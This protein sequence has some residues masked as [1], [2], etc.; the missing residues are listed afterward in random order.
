MRLLTVESHRS[1]PICTAEFAREEDS[2]AE[3]V[4]ALS[5]NTCNNCQRNNYQPSGWMCSVLYQGNSGGGA[6]A[7]TYRP[8]QT[9]LDARTMLA[10][11]TALVSPG[12][13]ASLCEGKGK[14]VSKFNVTTDEH[15]VV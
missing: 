2:P 3:N 14:H 5:A 1:T 10:E 13:I 7:S 9:C 8:R 4:T 15:A 6:R 12:A 11:W